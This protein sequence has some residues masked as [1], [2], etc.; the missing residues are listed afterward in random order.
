MLLYVGKKGEGVK[1]YRL[2][3]NL[4]TALPLAAALAALIFLPDEIPV[5]FGM[6][7]L[8]DRWG[9]KYEMLPAAP[10]LAAVNVMLA[11]FYWKADALFKAGLMHGVGSP[12]DGRKVLWAAGI[13]TAVMNTGIALALACS[14][15]SPG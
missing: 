10:L 7:N 3:L 6:D 14:A 4:L 5:H 2:I 8:A 13:I 9:S 1:R 11:V 15:S 12:E